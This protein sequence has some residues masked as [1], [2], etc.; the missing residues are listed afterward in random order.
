DAIGN[1]NVSMPTG[2]LWGPNRALT[3]QA[4]GQL[5]NAS[6]FRQM[7]VAYRKGAPVHLDEIGNVMDD[8]ENNKVAS[9]FNGDRAVVLA[10]Q[11][12]PGTNTV[13]VANGVKT[14]LA[15]LRDQ[16]PPSVD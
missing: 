14:L 2:T 12:Q 16:I 9:W 4:N 3:I 15:S 8:V 1:Q 7:V 10:I 5:Q 6:Q 13:A 11:R